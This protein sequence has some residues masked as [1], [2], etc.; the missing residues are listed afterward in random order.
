MA[1]LGRNNQRP[2]P[3]GRSMW[4]DAGTWPWETGQLCEALAHLAEAFCSH[5]SPNANNFSCT[6]HCH[7]GKHLHYHCR[8]R[9]V[10]SR[11]GISIFPTPLQDPYRCAALLTRKTA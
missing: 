8:I 1:L 2:V 5:G 7:I 11:R 9:G 6:L 3:R 10:A 4:C